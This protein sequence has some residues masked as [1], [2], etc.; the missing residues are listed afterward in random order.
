[1]R[2]ASATDPTRHWAGVI[3]VAVAA[4]V[5][6]KV[7]IDRITSAEA[8]A[9]NAEAASA[10]CRDQQGALR[11]MKWPC[12]YSANADEG[13]S[14]GEEEEPIHI[15]SACSCADESVPRPRARDN[16]CWNRSEVRFAP[17]SGPRH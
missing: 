6:W 8:I 16:I 15:P 14:D 4:P 3:I 17:E 10:R 12:I 7:V 2:T 11:P 5:T 1:M 9:M 13:K